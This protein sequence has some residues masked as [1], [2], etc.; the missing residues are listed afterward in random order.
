MPH[1]NS[2]IRA[3]AMNLHIIYDI[4]G[5]EQ[6]G[7]ARRKVIPNLQLHRVV[8]QGI[9]IFRLSPHLPSQSKLQGSAQCR[10]EA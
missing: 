8:C 6:P 3:I 5:I 1:E 2:F 7:T 9:E 10:E 4:H